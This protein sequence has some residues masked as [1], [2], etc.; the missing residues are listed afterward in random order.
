MKRKL[1]SLA[2]AV[3]MV[4]PFAL[5]NANAS[6][7]YKKGDNAPMVAICKITDTIGE[8]RFKPKGECDQV[9]AAYNAWLVANTK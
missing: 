4:V 8:A 9:L 1:K 5:S 3:F 6:S 7:P 2:L